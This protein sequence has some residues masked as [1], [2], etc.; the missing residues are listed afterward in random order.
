MLI[1]YRSYLLEPA[2]P[3]T[4]PKSGLPRRIAKSVN[5]VSESSDVVVAKCV[6]MTPD[7]AEQQGRPA[8][9]VPFRARA[10]P[11]AGA[12][13]TRFVGPPP[14]SRRAEISVSD[15]QRRA[16]AGALRHDGDGNLM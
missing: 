11:C 15:P 3:A 7:E 16:R 10:A 6:P 13:P 14:I 8:G 9:R 12:I 4:F 5:L 2:L 1:M